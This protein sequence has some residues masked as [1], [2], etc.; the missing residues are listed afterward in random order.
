[1]GREYTKNIHTF[2][3]FALHESLV[4]SPPFSCILLI[5]LLASPK[6]PFFNMAFEPN[7][8]FFYVKK[9]INAALLLK[10]QKALVSRIH[11]GGWTSSSDETLLEECICMMVE[12]R[13][14]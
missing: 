7:F 9:L 13:M 5:S 10:L 2:A 3:H 14:R 1:M 8:A 12:R 4:F 11:M 6:T